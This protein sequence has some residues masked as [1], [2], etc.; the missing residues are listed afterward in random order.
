MTDQNPGGNHDQASGNGQGKDSVSYD[1]Y[2]K[3]L[4][5][6]KKQQQD[7]NDMKTRLD[8]YEQGKLEAEGK[9]KEA[10]ENQKRIAQTEK[11]KGLK[12]FKQASEKAIRSQFLREA[13]KLGCIDAEM[14]IKACD[15]SDL[16]LTEDLEFDPKKV[17]EKLQDL[18]KSKSYLFKKDFKL[19]GD[20]TPNNSHVSQKS[21]SE[22]SEA[23]LKNL[24]KQAK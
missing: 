16:D 1:T 14:A 8:E 20:L 6:K 12:I 11:E 4:A 23:E 22:L 21:L 2:S 17:Q 10:L 18:T 19:P 9:L 7:L 15:F 3:L 5:E 13:E 24:L